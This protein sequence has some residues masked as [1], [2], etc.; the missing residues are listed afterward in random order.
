MKLV[1]ASQMRELDRRTIEEVGVPGVVLME[2]AGLGALRHLERRYRDAFPGP[3]LVVAGRGNNGGDGYV[4]A[5]HLHNRGWQVTTVVLA[6]SEAVGGDAAI[7]L[8]ALRNCGGAVRF[9]ADEA[10]LAEIL[11]GCATAALVVDALLGTGLNNEVGGLYAQAIDWVNEQRAPVLAVDIPSGVD[12]DSGKILG[13]AVRADLTVTFAYAKVGHHCHPAVERVGSLETVDIGIPPR[14]EALVPLNH[15]LLTGKAVAR[16]LPERPETGHKGT[17][18]HL[19]VVAGSRGKSGAAVMTAEG[20]LRIGAGLVTAACPEGIHGV[21]ETKLTEA[22]TEPLLEVDGRFGLASLKQMAELWTDKQALAL[23]PGIGQGAELHALVPRLVQECPLPMVIDADGLN[24]LAR[25]VGPLAGRAEAGTVL[26]PHPGEMARLVGRSIAD[27]E[28]DR[29]ETARSFA[30]LCGAVVLLKGARTVVASPDGQVA[31][32]GS[33][34]PGMAS[35]G[36]GDVLTG[37][38]GGLLAQGLSPWDATCVGAHIHGL[39]AD[40]LTGRL[41]R[42]GMLA[43]DV[44][45]ELPAAREQ[46]EQLRRASC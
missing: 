7:N 15:Q 14:L 42:A 11:G 26:T 36:M 16:L 22:M 45:A 10:A 1:T 28:A 12:A 43:G 33:G 46:L 20:G 41:G 25:D 21:L 13:R 2:N 39:A 40:S 3:V 9:A 23:G 31:I 6:R 18:G 35:G 27:V 8:K 37:V 24:A 32:N 30:A 4:M 5:R 17:F 34:N 44:L 29:V 38:I 19:L